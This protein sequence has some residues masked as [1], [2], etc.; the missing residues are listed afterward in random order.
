MDNLHLQAEDMPVMLNV[1][2]P[3]FVGL[4]FAYHKATTLIIPISEGDTNSR[5]THYLA[6][7]QSV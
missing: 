3:K 5:G 2:S 4:L 7:S 1:S 6:E